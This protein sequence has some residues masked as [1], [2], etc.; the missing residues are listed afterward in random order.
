MPFDQS[1]L[2]LGSALAA[3]SPAMNFSAM[4]VMRPATV[5]LMVPLKMPPAFSAP[6]MNGGAVTPGCVR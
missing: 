6:L 3:S 4:P 1:F 5:L 2:S